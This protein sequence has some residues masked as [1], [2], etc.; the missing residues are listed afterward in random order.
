MVQDAARLVRR[1]TP[2]PGKRAL[3]Y[4]KLEPIHPSPILQGE[5]QQILQG[6][7][8]PTATGSK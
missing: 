7:A 5:L 1:F 4:Q 3:L 2:E 8:E 6:S